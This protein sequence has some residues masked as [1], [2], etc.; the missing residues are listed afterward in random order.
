MFEKPARLLAREMLKKGASLSGGNSITATL[1]SVAV[2]TYWLN[3]D[4]R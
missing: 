4:V 3:L 2:L 1:C